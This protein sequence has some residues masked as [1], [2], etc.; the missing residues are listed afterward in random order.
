MVQ[1]PE[2]GSHL[3]LGIGG[4]SRSLLPPIEQIVLPADR[5]D[6]DMLLAGP[7]IRGLLGDADPNL[8]RP[9][10][11]RLSTIAEFVPDIA[12][13]ELNPLLVSDDGVVAVDASVTLRRWPTNPLAGVRT[14]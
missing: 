9:L 4:L 14:V 8:L 2:I 5:A 7:R 1:S 12:V 6:V 13:V 10:C 3:Y 11:E